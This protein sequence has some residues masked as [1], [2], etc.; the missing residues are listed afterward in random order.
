MGK[1]LDTYRDA[2]AAKAAYGA[3]TTDA[4]DAA[5]LKRNVD[6]LVAIGGGKSSIA[7]Y[8]AIASH[9]SA[10]SGAPGTEEP[11]ARRTRFAKMA[12]LGLGKA[13]L[14]S[15]WKV[16]RVPVGLESDAVREVALESLHA[17][18]GH[19]R[20]EDAIASYSVIAGDLYPGDSLGAT[21]DAF[22]NLS[23]AVR[24]TDSARRMVSDIQSRRLDGEFAGRTLDQLITSFIE[25][26]AVS[27]DVNRAWEVMRERQRD[28]AVVKSEAGGVNIGGIRVPRKSG[29]E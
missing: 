13:E 15:A 23:Q 7:T 28:A 18:A 25:A 2:D 21:A 16:T 12:G 20:L 8:Q 26:Y 22:I 5:A 14:E 1:L 4:P 24:S 9:V 17:A 10:T 19:G 29:E 6:D 27:G 11:A 3:V